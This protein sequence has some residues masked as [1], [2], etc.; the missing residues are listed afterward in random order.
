MS[1]YFNQKTKKWDASFSYRDFE[2]NSRKKMKRG[3]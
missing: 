2:N 1:A 3:N